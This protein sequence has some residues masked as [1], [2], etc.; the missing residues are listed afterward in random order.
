MNLHISDKLGYHSG[1]KLLP[2]LGDYSVTSMG[3][4]LLWVSQVAPEVNP[5]RQTNHID[6]ISEYIYGNSLG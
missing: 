6:K 5:P 4:H 2:L 1:S 3:N